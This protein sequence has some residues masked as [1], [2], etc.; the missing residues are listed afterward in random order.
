MFNLA[1]GRV[2]L[3]LNNSVSV[4]KSFSSL[5]S[6]SILNLNIVYELNTWPHNP[7]N[8]FPL[9]FDYLVQ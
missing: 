3:K 1:N 4:Q 7:T 5:Y 6:N 9:K 2:K 8:N